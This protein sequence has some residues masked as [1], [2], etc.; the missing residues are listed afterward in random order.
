MSDVSPVSEISGTISSLGLLP[1]P[2]V[3]LCVLS[4][5]FCL[6]AHSLA[7]FPENSSIFFV[8]K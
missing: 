5:F 4:F 6:L 3:T 7:F 1:T 2:G 8:K